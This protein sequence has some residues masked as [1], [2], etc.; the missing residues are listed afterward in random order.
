MLDCVRCRR[1]ALFETAHPLPVAPLL[2][3]IEACTGTLGDLTFIAKPVRYLG[4]GLLLTNLP[5]PGRW[6][7][8]AKCS[9]VAALRGNLHM[10]ALHPRDQR[11]R[12]A[13]PQTTCKGR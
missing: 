9:R 5:L 12:A 6:L 11:Q 8:F 3:A 2:D 10:A 4:G 1:T 7:V 13:A